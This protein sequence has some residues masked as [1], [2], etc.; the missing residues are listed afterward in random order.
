MH[1]DVDAA[2]AARALV[3]ARPSPLLRR[4]LLGAFTLLQYCTLKTMDPVPKKMLPYAYAIVLLNVYSM[5]QLPRFSVAHAQMDWHH[6]AEVDDKGAQGPLYCGLS[7][8]FS[9]GWLPA[10]A[11]I[12]G[13]TPPSLP[14]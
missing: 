14:W 5:Q 1:A 9:D 3:L 11:I 4:H 7:G 12:V 6:A 10:D 2:R 13:D 8:V